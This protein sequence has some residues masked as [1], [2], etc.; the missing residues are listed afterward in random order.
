MIRTCVSATHLARQVVRTTM[1]HHRAG[2]AVVTRSWLRLAMAISEAVASSASPKRT[3]FC[4]VGGDWTGPGRLLR[5]RP[6]RRGR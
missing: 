1:A 3:A 2:K 4:A 6:S 5:W